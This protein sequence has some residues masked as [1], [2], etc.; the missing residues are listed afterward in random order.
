MYRDMHCLKFKLDEKLKIQKEWASP[1]IQRELAE[2]LK[3]CVFD[4]ILN[5]VRLG[6]YFGFIMIE[7]IYK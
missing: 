2:I 7:T 5:E 6:Q 4:G 1:N 3:Q